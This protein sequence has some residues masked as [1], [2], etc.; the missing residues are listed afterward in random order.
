VEPLSAVLARDASWP[1][2]EVAA[3]ALAGFTTDNRVGTVLLLASLRERHPLARAAAVAALVRVGE[4]GRSAILDEL[5][6]ALGSPRSG[7]RRRAVASLAR[8]REPAAAVVPM[9]AQALSDPH[10]KVRRDA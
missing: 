6:L 10:A 7:R 5:R 2:R 1:V 8:L 9:L 3:Q 4:P